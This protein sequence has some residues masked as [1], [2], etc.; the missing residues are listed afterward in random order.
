[1]SRPTL[2]IG[3]H[4]EQE[5]PWNVS[6]EVWNPI[7]GSYES[8]ASLDDGLFRL[9]DLAE[10]MRVMWMRHEPARTSL[11]DAPDPVHDGDSEWAE[12]RVSGQANSV[13]ETRNFDQHGWKKA[14]GRTAAIETICNEVGYDPL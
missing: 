7:V 14:T 1:V 8:M 2:K 6:L 12:L 3:R 11:K 13:Y 4:D 9:G 10:Q 5:P